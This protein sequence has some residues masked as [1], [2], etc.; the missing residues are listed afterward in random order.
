MSWESC[1]R[2]VGWELDLPS[3]VASLAEAAAC[4]LELDEASVHEEAARLLS[5]TRFVSS[6]PRNVDNVVSFRFA[7]NGVP[8][9]ASLLRGST[10]KK[11]RTTP[12]PTPLHLILSTVLQHALQLLF[13]ALVDYHR[14]H[15]AHTTTTQFSMTTSGVWAIQVGIAVNS[16]A[17]PPAFLRRST[18]GGGGV[19]VTVQNTLGKISSREKEGV[20]LRE[21]PLGEENNKAENSADPMEE[22]EEHLNGKRLRISNDTHNVNNRT[23]QVNEFFSK[24][25]EASQ[26]RLQRVEAEEEEKEHQRRPQRNSS[27]MDP[28]FSL[29]DLC[30]DRPLPVEV[31]GI[32]EMTPLQGLPTPPLR[33]LNDQ[34]KPRNPPLSVLPMGGYIPAK[35][36]SSLSSQKSPQKE[37]KKKTVQSKTRFV[38]IPSLCSSSVMR[39]PSL[40]VPFDRCCEHSLKDMGL[41]EGLLGAVHCEACG[42]VSGQAWFCLDD[43]FDCGTV[44]LW[45][46]RGAVLQ[47]RRTKIY[48]FRIAPPLHLDITLCIPKETPKDLASIVH[49]AAQ[50]YC[51]LHLG[52]AVVSQGYKPDSSASSVLYSSLTRGGRTRPIFLGWQGGEDVSIDNVTEGELCR[53]VWTEVVGRSTSVPA[54][55]GP[56]LQHVATAVLRYVQKGKARCRKVYVSRGCLVGMTDAEGGGSA[57][58]ED[59]LSLTVGSDCAVWRGWEVPGGGGG[60]GDGGVPSVYLT[61]SNAAAK[62]HLLLCSVGVGGGGG[63][64]DGGMY[65]QCLN[66]LCGIEC[67]AERQYEELTFLL[68]SFVLF[69]TD[70]EGSVAENEPR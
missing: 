13:T 28:P 8:G 34:K 66:F 36:S 63:D 1:G 46:S 50:R 55:Q 35:V 49:K 60:G 70:I 44:G 16:V 15:S 24:T 5:W 3:P 9:R 67:V 38:L 30:S 33:K 57:D 40:A 27:V 7:C 18:P 19:V 56:T 4:R 41:A 58:S 47:P 2:R 59:A 52:T 10:R 61:T 64:G 20:A 29:M 62:K 68:A 21:M 42:T 48:P 23:L 22:G 31:Q 12:I 11:Q 43:V 51:N 32:S 45:V 25:E 17:L 65:P 39:R 53:R 54:V 6:R 26:K 14:G 69:G 37:E